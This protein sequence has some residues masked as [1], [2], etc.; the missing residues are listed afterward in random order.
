LTGAAAAVQLLGAAEAERVWRREF[1]VGGDTASATRRWLRASLSEHVVRERL[2]TAAL[3]IEEIVASSMRRTLANQ[4]ITVL[5]AVEAQLLR[6]DV[7]D[8]ELDGA[9]PS[10]AEMRGPIRGLSLV[11]SKAR[12]WGM[13]L[14]P[15]ARVWFAI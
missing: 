3:L 1:P 6:V 15:P 10:A 7:I 4:Q 5:L 2:E 12:S 11:A 14:G 8:T 9:R 13:T